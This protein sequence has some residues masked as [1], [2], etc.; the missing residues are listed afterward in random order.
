M[1][2]LAGS[3]TALTAVDSDADR[4]QRVADNLDR[5]GL[6]AT[7]VTADASTP[8]GW[9]DGQPFDRILLDAPCSGSGVIRRHP[10]IKLLRRKSDIAEL[11]DSQ[12][13]MLR[14]LW[15][16]LAP[17]GSLLYVTCSVL[18]EE[19]EAVV[20]R[21][22]HESGDAQERRVLPNNNIRD[23]MHDKTCGYQ[24]LPGIS[25]LDGFFYACLDKVP[26]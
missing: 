12:T 7:L 1:L 8:G 19:N 18:A 26:E 10:D 9:W 23:L 11:A 4:L 25:D 3:N 5:L 13:R 15:P 22:L 16:L 21:F 6:D 14:A 20:G 2:E 24:I 17:S